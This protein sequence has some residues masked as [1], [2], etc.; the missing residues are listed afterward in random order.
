M[1]IFRKKLP[2]VVWNLGWVSFFTDISSEMLYPIIPIFLT[3]V[4]GASVLMVGIIEGLAEGTASFFKVIMGYWSDRLQKRKIFAVAGY[5]ESAIGKIIIAFSYS[6]SWVYIGKLIDRIGKGTRTGARDALLLEAAD[7]T[8]TGL[9]FGFHRSMDS[10]GAVIGPAIVMILLYVFHNNIR[11][12]LY[13]ASVPTLFSLIFFIFVKDARKKI[14]TSK[15][16]FSFTL[17]QFSSQFKIFLL[18]LSIF[19][20]GN[21][22]DSFLILRA[23]SLGLSLFLV[24]TAYIL[25]NIVYTVV[26]APAGSIAD[27][28]GP[29]KVFLLGL[30]IY[31]FVYTLFAFNKNPLLIWPLFAIYGFYIALTDG[32]SKTIAGLMIHKEQSGTAYGLLYTVTSVFTLLA[33]VLGGI[34]WSLISPS[35]TFIF[36]AICALISFVL[37]SR[38]LSGS[39]QIFEIKTLDKNVK[40][41]DSIPMYKKIII[42][43]IIVLVF[44]GSV[45]ILNIIQAKN[46]PKIV[47]ATTNKTSH[48][49]ELFATSQY[50]PFAFQIAPGELSPDAR[51]ALS[52]F[53]MQRKKLSKGYIEVKIRPAFRGYAFQTFIV[54]PGYKMFFA[55]LPD[56][57]GD[58]NDSYEIDFLSLDVPVLVD[59][60]G[61]IINL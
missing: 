45:S 7:K 18:G 44:I 5:L 40:E 11:L 51:Q 23:K 43:I 56:A 31:A 10:L 50:V 4:L 30:L 8:D 46:P 19:T 53:I 13:V 33:S 22:S 57:E 24:I 25:Y 12:I 3:Q 21:S 58:I 55:T 39:I 26:S 2:S 35:A 1:N 20:L 59:N 41:S 60:K 27:K 32:I 61:Y 37:L 48:T 29:K 6:W 52:Y 9:I 16:K 17:S 15:L 14:V 28:I 36:G 47:Q 34:F 42:G 49:K 54:K 38:Y